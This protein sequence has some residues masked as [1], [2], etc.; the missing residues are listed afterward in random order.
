MKIIYIINSFGVGGA[1]RHLLNLVRDTTT[2]KYDVSVVALEKKI[3]GGAA[4]I[5]RELLDAG[6]R[7]FYLNSYLASDI[8][9]CIAFINI[10]RRINPDIL[11]SHLPRSD[12]LASI[13]KLLF[14]KIKWIFTVHDTYTEDKYRGYWV[15]PYLKKNWQS[16]DHT[17][18]VSRHV[19]EWTIECYS[20]SKEKCS[21]IYHGVQLY[22]TTNK[23]KN[24][25][26]SILIGCLARF[27]KR[28]GIETL[29]YA[30]KEVVKQYP[31]SQLL[32][33]GSD[34]TN[35]SYKI[36]N[37]A[38]TLKI[39]EHVKIIGF[40][41]TPYDFLNS[42]DVFAYASY[43]EGFGIV[44]IEAMSV[45]CPIVASDIYPIN[46]ILEK[47]V[48]GLLAEPGDHQS[49]A[50]SII[51]YLSNSKKRDRFVEKAYERCISDFSLGMSLEKVNNLYLRIIA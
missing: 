42:L 37:L 10:L 22:D 35:Y 25:N 2:R 24:S 19:K 9:R 29:I 8:G 23:K 4:S 14:P 31:N 12:F 32:L 18:S 20:L 13:G 17:I 16:A 38:R 36:R 45:K 26:G 47:D 21:V 50:L 44:L 7:I 30:M 43:S 1:E 39:E 6:A 41:Q 34:P 15:L 3:K 33:A 51:D 11:H 40:C 48:S 49:F 27:E 5:E 46:Y 28:K